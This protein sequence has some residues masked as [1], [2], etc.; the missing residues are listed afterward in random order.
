[1]IERKINHSIINHRKFRL[2]TNLSIT[3]DQNRSQ[4]IIE[5]K[6]KLLTIVSLIFI[7]ETYK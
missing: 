1:M 3:I 6:E 2:F 4:P 5:Q 7:Y